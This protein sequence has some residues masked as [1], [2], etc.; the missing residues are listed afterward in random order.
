M[1]RE[2]LPPSHFCPLAAVLQTSL[3]LLPHLMGWGGGIEAQG[4]AGLLEVPSHSLSEVG[5]IGTQV[6][7]YVS[8]ALRGHYLLEAFSMTS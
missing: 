2:S 4:E 6:C 5:R 3:G 7:G 1:G 8:A